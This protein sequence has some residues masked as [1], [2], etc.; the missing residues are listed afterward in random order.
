VDSNFEMKKFMI[1]CRSAEGRH[2]AINIA[3]HIDKVVSSI[4]ALKASTLRHCVTDNA[5]AMLAAVPKLTKKIDI[6][7][8]CID[9]LLNLIVKATNKS[10]PEIDTAI[11][12]C[13]DLSGRVHHAPL[14][15]QRIK[16]E[17]WNL[18]N[19]SNSIECKFRKIISPVDTRWNSTL[20]MLKSIHQLRPALESLQDGRF[21]ETEKTDTKLKN[22]IPSPT[23]FQIIEQIIPILEKALFMSEILSG[24]KKPTIQHVRMTYMPCSPKNDVYFLL[25]IKI[26]ICYLKLFL[27]SGNSFAG[28]HGSH[29]QSFGK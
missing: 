25:Y 12:E 8:G 3:G 1:A 27:V 18:R 11:K 6:G 10:I 23:S 2:T 13:R 26:L 9:H 5:S 7:L 19:D 4:L 29:A 17:C 14:D 22:L 20:F 28:Q 15:Q 21:D 16:R 24:D